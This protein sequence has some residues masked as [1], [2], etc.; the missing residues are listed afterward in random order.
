M[1]AERYRL[2]FA[3]SCQEGREDGSSVADTDTEEESDEYENALEEVEI[4]QSSELYKTIVAA[5]IEDDQALEN[6][7]DDDEFD[8][9]ID[10]PPPAEKTEK[11][12]KDIE[13]VGEVSSIVQSESNVKTDITNDTAES[14]VDD[15]DNVHVLLEEAAGD[16]IKR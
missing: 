11:I 8:Q 12:N 7:M 9:D 15:A 3:R 13:D 10:N 1:F 5:I 6:E 4:D 14:A 16:D 2:Q